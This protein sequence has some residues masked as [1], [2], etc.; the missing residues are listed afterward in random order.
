[1]KLVQT[2]P[3]LPMSVSF[4][5]A[6]FYFYMYIKKIGDRTNLSFTWVCL[7]MCFYAWQ[8]YMNYNETSFHYNVLWIKFFYFTFPFFPVAFIHFAY[9]FTKQRSHKV[10]WVLTVGGIMASIAMFVMFLPPAGEKPVYIRV[11]MLDFS[12]V[13]FLGSR[14]IEWAKNLVLAA[15]IGITIHALILIAKYYRSGNTFALPIFIGGLL[16]FLCG[17]NDAFI[18]TRV[19]SFVY[20]TEYGGMFLIIGMALA[21]IDQMAKTS[22]E[23][24][25]IK[26]LSA[27]GKMAAEVVHD[28][29]TPL[30]AIK[31]AASIAKKDGTGPDV[32][33]KY[34][35]MIEQETSRLSDLSFDILQYVS[36]D[37]AL[38]KKR[39][40]LKNYMEEISFLLQ[41]DF[42]RH[43]I[44]F[45]YVLDYDGPAHLDPDGFKRVIINLATNARECFGN[46]PG[47]TQAPEFVIGVQKQAG[48]IVF[49]FS[50]NGPGIPDEIR[51]QLF[52]PFTSHGKKHGTGL[53]LAI[54]KQIVDHHG[55]SITCE[56]DMNTGTTFRIT[57]PD[58]P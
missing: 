51:Q 28:L 39:V 1:M 9:D 12:Y 22:K 30:D 49:T 20:L 44:D 47:I 3:L 19:Y 27:V 25:E 23:M 36:N 35:S 43:G 6:L 33:G 29:T 11:D 7:Y 5:V 2:L 26:A 32:Q 14:S 17:V 31:L 16:F 55:G 34:L 13:A 53:G 18:E 45:R 50:D 54:S 15:A 52:E 40:D 37:G 58:A 10:P 4:L 24:S 56:S 38:S 46:H 41:K 57:L 42:N 21:L 48:Q 8:C